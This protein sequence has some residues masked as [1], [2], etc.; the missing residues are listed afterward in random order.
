MVFW[1]LAMLLSLAGCRKPAEPP[2]ALKKTKSPD[3]GVSLASLDVPWQMQ[4]KADIEAAAARHPELRFLIEDASGDPERQ[5]AQIKKFLEKG[6]KAIIVSPQDA[7]SLTEPLAVVFAAGIPVVVLD[8]P[9]IGDKYSCFIAADPK[10]IGALAGRWLADKL[11]GKGKIV[12]L[13]GP[14]D[15]LRA[16]DLHDAF[17]SQLLDPGYRFV[18]EGFLDPPKQDAAKLMAEALNQVRQ[19]DAVFAYD[20][21]SARGAYDAAKAAGREI[22]VLWIGVGGLPAEGRAYVSEGI[23]SASLLYPTGGAEAVEAA[24]KLLSG[25]KVP[26]NFV[27]AT[28]VFAK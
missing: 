12:E 18:F 26:K 8:R 24:V 21:L 6:V 10:Q 19:F 28:E 7:Q 16:Q 15:S 3:V 14:A 2:A 11:T 27:P 5:R 23:L 13:K 20:D 4:M 25:Q 17:R 9:L 1:F 22:G